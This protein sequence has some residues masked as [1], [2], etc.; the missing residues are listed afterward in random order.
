MLLIYH[1]R[2]MS[3]N[4]QSK[5]MHHVPT[6]WK[7]RG[8]KMRRC[9]E[10]PP[11]ASTSAYYAYYAT[12]QGQTNTTLLSEPALDPCICFIFF[13]P[14]ALHNMNFTL[15]SPAEFLSHVYSVTRRVCMA[16]LAGKYFSKLLELSSTVSVMTEWISKSSTRCVNKDVHLQIIA[17][18]P[19]YDIL[20]FCNIKTKV[21]LTYLDAVKGRQSEFFV[22]NY[23]ILN[24]S[25][26]IHYRTS[27]PLWY[28]SC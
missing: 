21:H 26:Q 3:D 14:W 20:L 8:M 9:R 18:V 15:S 25:D 27:F 4:P 22:V 12:D 1:L 16:P 28:C 10:Q 13:C 19:R 23:Q 17:F 24:I 7:D 6:G 11:S 2:K 5:Y